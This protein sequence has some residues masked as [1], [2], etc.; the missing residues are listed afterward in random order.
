MESNAFVAIPQVATRLGLPRRAVL[1]LIRRGELR[2]YRFGRKGTRVRVD[3]LE[4]F[5]EASL[6]APAKVAKEAPRG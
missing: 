1:G 4:R 2:A 5:I 3:D 6:V